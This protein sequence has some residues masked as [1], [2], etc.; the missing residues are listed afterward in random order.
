[1]EK[2]HQNLPRTTVEQHVRRKA[3]EIEHTKAKT[4]RILGLMSKKV[5]VDRKFPY[6]TNSKL[7]EA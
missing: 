4:N 2:H 1:M 5:K 6:M 7:R 3:R